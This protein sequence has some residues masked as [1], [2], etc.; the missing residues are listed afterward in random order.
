[1]VAERMELSAE[2]RNLPP[3]AYKNADGSRRAAGR[4]ITSAE[5]E[6]ETKGNEQQATQAKEYAVN[7]EG[8]LQKVC[9]GIL[10]LMDESL[11]LSAS[12]GEPREFYYE[13]KGDYYRFLAECVTDDAKSKV[14]EEVTIPVARPLPRALGRPVREPHRA[15]GAEDCGSSTSA[16]HCQDR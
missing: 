16:V 14:A 2:Q 1:M 4:I 10:A 6:K 11:I 13:M 8:E 15:D 7:L 9:E 12:T 3:A 5:Y